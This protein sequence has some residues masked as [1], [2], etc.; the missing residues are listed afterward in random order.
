MMPFLA[1]ALLLVGCAQPTKSASS[2]SNTPYPNDSSYAVGSES[3]SN[4]GSLA[5]FSVSFVNYD[6]SV[7]YETTVLQGGTAVYVGDVPARPDSDSSTFTF[8]GWNRSLNNIQSDMVFVAQFASKARS[9]KAQFVNYDGALLDVENVF[10]GD[11]AIY[12]GDPPE[13]PTTLRATYSWTG[14]DKPL[15]N[16]KENT[17]FTAQF[18]ETINRYTVTFK[19]YD[20]T[21]LYRKTVDYG[22]TVTY[23]GVTPT[24]PA[25]GRY[26]YTFKS[27]DFPLTSVTHDLTLTAQFAESIRDLTSGFTLSYDSY[28][29]RYKIESYSGTDT[30]VYVASTFDDG[31]HGVHPISVIGNNVFSDYH[32]TNHVR[33]V[34]L[35]DNV[36][37]LEYAAFESASALEKVRL[38][39]SLLTIGERCFEY[40]E[41]FA[42]LDLP[43]SVSTIGQS[44]F[45]NVKSGFLLNIDAKNPYFVFEDHL[46]KNKD[47]TII[48]E[49]IGLPSSSVLTIPEGATAIDG[50]AFAYCNNLTRLTLPS[51]LTTI[52]DMAFFNSGLLSLTFK[53]SP[54][55]IGSNAFNA[56]YG[57]QSIDFGTKIVSL[58]SSCFQYC[59]SLTSISLPGSVTTI[60]NAFQNCSQLQTSSVDSTNPNFYSLDGVTYSK[61]GSSIVIFPARKSG[62]L[63]LPAGLSSF[64]SSINNNG[65]SL[66]SI[67][68]PATNTKYSTQDGVLY[69]KEAKVLLLTPGMITSLTVP[70]TVT[71]IGQQASK[72]ASALVSLSLDAGLTGIESEAFEG[73]TSLTSTAFPSGLTHLDN[74]CFSNTGLTSI[75]IPKGV[76]QQGYGIFQS[77]NNL[78]SAVLEEGLTSIGSNIFSSCGNF[79]S[80]TLPSTL[81]TL[82]NN[83]FWGTNLKEITLPDSVD[84]MGDNCFG[85]CRSL[86]KVTLGAGL[87]HLGNY[88]FS[89][90]YALE[91]VIFDD[92]LTSIGS[93]IFQNC[94]ILNTLVLPANLTSTNSDTFSNSSLT[95][96]FFKATTNQLTN[97]VCP[98]GC[99][100]Y[101]YSETA[102]N[103]GSHWHYVNNVPTVWAKT[104]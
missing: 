30:D 44:A 35:E 93:G 24:R 18:S 56:C 19:N 5:T 68:I 73:C 46:L 33:S 74:Y 8:T 2:E 7:L 83:A 81:T 78:A 90:C 9:F 15:A 66:S 21:L 96:L 95:S 37:V 34:F 59:S 28:K 47:K 22:E 31:T 65:N 98:S 100:Y 62:T 52:G 79:A 10:Y 36:T 88:M 67:T 14:W 94:N 72:L 87:T 48:H 17:T 92:A 45:Y 58:G 85:Y 64:D 61:D 3:S 57:L 1:S 71:T 29:K 39:D 11:T 103:D 60:S 51:S 40:D 53:D 101:F 54:V 25:E 104:S 55:S 80:V 32:V 27:W 49:A 102:N 26:N 6:N 16:I 41:K 86:K 76:S 13:K 12:A 38:S 91:N 23:S 84:Q 97:F 77:C 42:S 20:G 70:A 75:T 63:S 99:R 69:D 43:A 50:Y 82:Q 89:Q 4:L